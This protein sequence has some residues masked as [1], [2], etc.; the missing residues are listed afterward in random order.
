MEHNFIELECKVF[1]KV[2]EPLINLV[3]C[4]LFITCGAICIHFHEKSNLV[5]E[6]ESLKIYR[7]SKGWRKIKIF[8][9]SKS[10]GIALGSLMVVTGIVF[11]V[12]FL[13]AV[14]NIRYINNLIFIVL[15]FLDGQ[16]YI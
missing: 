14:K 4:V 2:Q 15:T 1:L 13:I 5:S 16:V 6:L 12:D 3:G 7:N 9:Y 8:Q 11:L 10:A